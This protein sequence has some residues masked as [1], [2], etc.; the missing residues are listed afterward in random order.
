MLALLAMLTL[1]QPNGGFRWT[2]APW[3]AALVCEP[4]SALAPHLFTAGNLRLRDNDSEWL[5]VSR[6]MDVPPD[7]LRL[8]TQVHGADVAVAHEGS[9]SWRQPAADAIVS[10]DPDVAIAVRVADCAPVLIADP[11]RRAVAA[12]HAGWRGTMRGVAAAAVRAMVEEF[13]VEPD[14]LIAAIGPCLGPCCGEM[15]S[16]VVDMFRQAG[17]SPESLG[18]WFL[19]GTSGR[20]HFDAWRANRDQLELAG[21]RPDRIFCAEICTKSHPDVFHS[22]RAHGA[23]TGRMLGIIRAGRPAE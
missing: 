13:G 18:R 20:P 3:G 19:D 1:P 12:V 2:Q 6:V 14:R 15:G 8:I 22:Y 17:H 11:G 9:G 21:V 5:D 4:L 23:G 16:E 10:N 7:R